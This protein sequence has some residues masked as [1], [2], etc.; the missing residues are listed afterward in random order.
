MDQD[1]IA[2][3]P[4]KMKHDTPENRAIADAHTILRV[5]VGSGLHGI[6]IPG[7]DDR[8]E[9]ALVCEPPEYVIGLRKFEQYEY[10]TQLNH[11]RSGPGDL[12]FI[13]YSLHKWAKL[14]ATGN[15]TLLLLLFAP[16]SEVLHAEWPGHSLRAQRS[17]FISRGAGDRFIGYLERQRDRMLGILSQ[18]TNRPELV[19][20]HGFDTK[21][22]AHAVRLGIQGV[23][24]LSTGKITLP[25]PHPDR[26][27]LIGIREGKH[28]KDEVLAVIEML[29]EKLVELRATSE[30]PEH[31][32]Y[33]RINRWLPE[34][35]RQWW[36]E[37]GL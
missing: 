19:A 35:Y 17:M 10:R 11:V 4:V 23:E 31:A 5:Q 7:T 2:S 25:I 15:P 14:A 33:D 30:L 26:A 32:D 12:D 13:A 29:R 27:Y 6:A 21:F 3:T 9:M 8:D 22:G 24:L 1:M 28:S 16:D 20:L 36:A 18:R 34:V 37:K